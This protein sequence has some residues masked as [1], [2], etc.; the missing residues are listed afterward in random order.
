M[1]HQFDLKGNRGLVYYQKITAENAKGNIQAGDLLGSPKEM[2]KQPLDFVG[3]KNIEKEELG[4]ISYWWTTSW[5]YIR[6]LPNSNL[7]L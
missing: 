1:C 4:Y 2:S 5:S 6:I 3:T 7:V